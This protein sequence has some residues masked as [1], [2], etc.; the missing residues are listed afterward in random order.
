MSLWNKEKSGVLILDL[1]TSL[2]IIWF[3]I[4]IFGGIINTLSKNCK[5]TALRYQLNNFRMVLMLYKELKGNY[6]QELGV[7][8]KTD[9]KPT[10]YAQPVYSEKLLI[11]FKQGLR[12]EVLDAFGSRLYY[13]PQK[14][15]IRSQTKGYE[16]W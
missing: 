13:D 10:Q 8:L 5:E 11:G 15:M 3:L 4:W 2:T 1:I 9:Y 7:L 6:P 14:G 16:N 12:G